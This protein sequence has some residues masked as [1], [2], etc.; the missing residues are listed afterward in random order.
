MQTQT[1][2]IPDVQGFMKDRAILTAAEL[3]LFTELDKD[4]VSATDLADKLDLDERA[5]TRLL[6][7]LITFDLL[8]KEEDKY[9]TTAKG[10][11]L[12]ALH[13]KSV[14][15]LFKHASRLWNNWSHLTETVRKGINPHLHALGDNPVPDE[16]RN[17]FIY[18]MHIRAQ[19]LTGKISNAYDLRPFKK[20]LDIGGGSGAYTIAFLQKS[21]QMQ[22][23]LFDLEPVISIA[24]EMTGQA[25]LNDRV[26]LVA[27]NYNKDELPG[28]CDL[29]L[30]S[31]IIHQ[32]SPEENRT[33][34]RKIYRALNKGGTLLI[35]D[36]VMDESRTQ[37]PRGALF[38][39]NML[40]S[41]PAGDTYT[42]EEIRKDLEMAGFDD[43]NMV[44]RGKR[45]DC[46]VEAR[47]LH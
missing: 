12:S 46:L 19:S 41:T 2:A 27:G 23:I 9:Q 21:P 26:R 28:G 29:A 40:V 33:L 44:L 13:P 42:F 36:H 25:K 32:N 10:S 17:A 11:Y 20:L 45:M 18:S 35:R 38:A 3:D 16:D 6:D 4:P 1:D 34:Y 5:T 37:P 15:P 39:L 43:V 47:K 22:A 14:L 7:C 8:K 24:R 30:L 31:A